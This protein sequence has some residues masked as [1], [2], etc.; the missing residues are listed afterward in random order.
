MAETWCDDS[1]GQYCNPEKFCGG[2]FAETPFSRKIE[3]LR[4]LNLR[5]AQN[6]VGG[7][8]LVFCGI[9]AF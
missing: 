2:F 7:G 9:N 5:D 1:F 8:C 6:K 3:N 4:V